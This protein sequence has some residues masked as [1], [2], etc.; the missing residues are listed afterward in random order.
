MLTPVPTALHQPMLQ[1]RDERKIR[2]EE[3]KKERQAVH[4]ALSPRGGGIPAYGD[5]G[6]RESGMP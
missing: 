5:N 4:H 2:K 6:V 3:K 1:G